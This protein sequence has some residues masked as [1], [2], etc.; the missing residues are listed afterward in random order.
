MVSNLQESGY[1]TLGVWIIWKIN[2]ELQYPSKYSNELI[3]QRK[4]KYE[5]KIFYGFF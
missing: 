4:V 3:Q 1:R 2:L 5:D